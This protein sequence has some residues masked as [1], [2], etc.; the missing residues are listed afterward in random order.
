MPR[1]RV[2]LPWIRVPSSGRARA[3]A[4]SPR[5]L[6]TPVG[7][8]GVA[9]HPSGDPDERE[10]SSARPSNA[11]ID[12]RSGARHRHGGAQ[13]RDR[14]APQ[15]SACAIAYPRP[16]SASFAAGSVMSEDSS[17]GKEQR[18]ARGSRPPSSYEPGSPCPLF[19]GVTERVISACRGTVHLCLFVWGH[20]W[21][22]FFLNLHSSSSRLR[23]CR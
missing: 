23:N 21:V 14:R 18:L 7:S 4:V 12:V 1:R 10:D 6:A 20:D 16:A 13:H 19:S 17:H 2:S 5:R 15:W 8:W 9:A 11:K 22:M 3:V